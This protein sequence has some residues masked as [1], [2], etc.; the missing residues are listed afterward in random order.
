MLVSMAKDP[1]ER[2]RR[3]REG[4]EFLD[5]LRGRSA[6]AVSRMD[7]L[8]AG[9]AQGRRSPLKSVRMGLARSLGFVML[10]ARLAG[11][12]RLDL[13][14]RL[15]AGVFSFCLRAGGSLA[16]AVSFFRLGARRADA[17]DLARRSRS[18][19]RSRAR[20][21]RFTRTWR[22]SAGWNTRASSSLFTLA[23]PDDP[24]LGVV[25]RACSAE[26][27]ELDMEIVVSK[28]RIGY[29]PKV[30]N[31]ANAAPFIKHDLL[32]H[33]R[34]GHPRRPGFPAPHGGAAQ[35]RR[36]WGWSPA[37]TSARRRAGSGRAWRRCPSTRTSCRRR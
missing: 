33:V 25:L 7:A 24:A 18:S 13:A 36:A 9:R 4:K 3:L 20:T 8:E 34:L 28:N 2:K 21:G 27:P 6:P 19:S 15:A 11:G 32:L 16:A 37:S 26:F 10:A 14:R 31:I 35:R 1:A 12:R 23:S 29:N 22:A 5:Y 30:N 17:R